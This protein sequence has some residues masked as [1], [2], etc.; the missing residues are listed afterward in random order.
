MHPDTSGDA[1]GSV[2]RNVSP[3]DCPRENSV[4]LLNYISGR[5]M[6]ILY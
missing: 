3:E 1:G 5:K 2:G 6:L 4:I